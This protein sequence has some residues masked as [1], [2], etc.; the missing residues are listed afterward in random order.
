MGK[1]SVAQFICRYMLVMLAVFTFAGIE[2]YGGVLAA[3]PKTPTIFWSEKKRDK[4]WNSLFSQAI[5]TDNLKEAQ[6]IL[7]DEGDRINLDAFTPKASKVTFQED[8]E[9]SYV[10]ATTLK[11]RLSYEMDNMGEYRKS[12]ETLSFLKEH[13]SCARDGFHFGWTRRMRPLDIAINSLK[14]LRKEIEDYS[15]ENWYNAVCG[16]DLYNTKGNM[17]ILGEHLREL[18][19]FQGDGEKD[20]NMELVNTLLLFDDIAIDRWMCWRD[21]PMVMAIKR[22]HMELIRVLCEKGVNVT[23]TV[24]GGETFLHYAFKHLS[25]KNFIDV[26]GL[27]LEHGTSL[28][29]RNSDG[30]TVLDYV[31]EAG[32]NKNKEVISYLESLGAVRARKKIGK[33]GVIARNENIAEQQAVRGKENVEDE[34]E[35]VATVC[36][37]EN[38]E[39]QESVYESQ[40]V[41][42]LIKKFNNQ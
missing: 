7:R 4:Y 28:N 41:K 17:R 5:L 24:G 33:G 11:A 8:D 32:E 26:S 42:E 23:D 31:Y 22:G 9:V 6:D 36:R 29:A 13:N 27:L 14:D 40:S 2:V 18:I 37:S 3:P 16:S 21:Q 12:M 30:K 1:S 38:T 20:V 19:S 10:S 34:K 35:E 25:G 39:E 15:S